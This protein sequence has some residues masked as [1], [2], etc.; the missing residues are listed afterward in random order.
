MIGMS[1]AGKSTLGVLLAKALGKNFF[2]TDLLL[3]QTEGCLLQETIDRKGVE[4]FM[5]LEERAISKLKL[6]GC[7]IA[8]GG[9]V[10][11][12]K[13][14]MEHLR[15][16]GRVVYLRV[17]FEELSGRLSN[18]TTRG[19]VF[20]GAGDLRAVYEERLPLYERYADLT[21][22]C[23]GHSVED[24]VRAIVSALEEKKQAETT[25]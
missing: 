3:Q 5:S 15:R 18:I 19:I 23:T 2:D 9:S 8:T 13:R 7:V 25:K 14:G 4:Y 1:G 6:R 17:S 16:S 11:Y 12:S 22:D 24:S 20:K 21:V 10:V